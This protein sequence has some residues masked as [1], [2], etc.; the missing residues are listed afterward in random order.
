MTF[1]N[2]FY[3]IAFNCLRSIRLA[4]K[5]PTSYKNTRGKETN[6]WLNTS[7]G[8]II[9]AKVSTSTKACLRYFFKNE[10]VINPVLLKKNISTGSSKITPDERITELNVLV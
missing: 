8:V 2:I 9:A 10:A 3:L 5:I 4:S 1:F 7:G 6:I